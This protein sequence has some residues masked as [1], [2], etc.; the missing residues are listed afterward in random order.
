[1]IQRNHISGGKAISQE[2]AVRSGAV[3]LSIKN[4]RKSSP[5]KLMSTNLFPQMDFFHY[6]E[7]IFRLAETCPNLPLPKP[8]SS[9][10][11]TSSSCW[12]VV[13]YKSSHGLTA[14]SFL[15]AVREKVV[16]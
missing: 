9:A 16:D 4:L 1:M 5:L 12:A 8:P 3:M 10:Y 14:D 7:V 15:R 6:E 11:F 2:I 13:V